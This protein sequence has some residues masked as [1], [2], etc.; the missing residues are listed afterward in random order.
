MQNSH[1]DMRFIALQFAIK[2][3]FVK[4]PSICLKGDLALKRMEGCYFYTYDFRGNPVSL[5]VNEGCGTVE[6]YIGHVTP[7]DIKE[8]RSLF[9]IW[10]TGDMGKSFDQVFNET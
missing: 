8:T 9:G 1:T 3:L 5:V 2:H 10:K 7:K 6:W 4:T